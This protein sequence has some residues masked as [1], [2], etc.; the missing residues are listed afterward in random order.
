MNQVINRS[1]YNEPSQQTALS[2]NHHIAL[3]FEGKAKAE[4]RGKVQCPSIHSLL[5]HIGSNAD[6]QLTKVTTQP[7]LAYKD[8]SSLIQPPNPPVYE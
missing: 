7:V 4:G 6:L 1:H 3:G 2:Q 5:D 8:P